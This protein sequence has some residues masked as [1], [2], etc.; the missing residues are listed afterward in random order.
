MTTSL[1]KKEGGLQQNIKFSQK[2]QASATLRNA[3]RKR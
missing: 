1:V 3:I 2:I